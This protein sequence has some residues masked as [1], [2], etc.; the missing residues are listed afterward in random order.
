MIGASRPA[1]NAAA[2]KTEPSSGRAGRP[3]L[4]FDTPSAHLTPRRSL[5]SDMA[6]RI[7]SAWRW[8]VEAVMTRQSMRMRSGPMP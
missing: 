3:K 8:L 2:K 1:P 7:C 6:R 4:M 5:H